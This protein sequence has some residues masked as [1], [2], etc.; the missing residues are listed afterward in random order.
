[1]KGVPALFVGLVDDAAM[2]PPGSAEVPQALAAHRE[3]RRSWFAPMVGPLV[4]SDQKL[5]ELGRALQRIEE[6]SAPPVTADLDVSVV[7][8]SGA[9]GL[10]SLAG[11]QPVGL[12]LRAVESALRDLD[13]LAVNAS[14]VVSAAGE[15]D[16]GVHAFVE[17]PYAPGWER[18]VEVVEAA[19]LFGK[20]R[21]G[22]PGPADTPS[23]TQLAHQ[24]SV[25]VEAALPFKATAGLHHAWPAPGPEA[26]QPRQHGF[27]SLL[28]AVDAL[29]A[30][31]SQAEAA[32][33]LAGGDPAAVLSA[34]AGWSDT[35]SASVRRRLRSF[36]CCGVTDPLA[37]L[38]ALGLLEEP[39]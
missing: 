10:V 7:N 6:P 19:G 20:L 36:G 18:A 26:D 13:D 14:R 32:E 17:L 35:R 37:D 38:V 39:R 28:A 15:L 8:T 34:L 12:R 25:L 16:A 21:T 9:G 4:V 3:Y 23:T 22:G 11:R 2:F 1:M 27:L 31:G 24:L 30:G 5:A 29:V 33:L